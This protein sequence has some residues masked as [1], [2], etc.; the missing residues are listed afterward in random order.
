MVAA[1]SII[2]LLATVGG[3]V[4]SPK[5]LNSDITLLIDNDL[6]G[7]ESPTA[8]SGVIILGPR[9]L[10]DASTACQA[11]GEQLWSPELKTASIRPNLDYL[12]YTKSAQRQTKYWIAPK[13]V[14]TRTIDA[15]GDYAW[16]NASSRLPVLCSHTAPFS[17]ETI[18]DTSPKWQVT[19]RSN[20]EYLTGF[21]DR[22]S[23]RFLGLRYAPQPERFTYSEPYVGNGVNSSAMEYGSQC[24]QSGGGSEDCLFLN[25]WTNF[26]PG[27]H[28]SKQDLKPVMFWIHGGAFTSGTANDPNLDGGNLASRGDVVVVGINYRLGSLG[29]LALPDGATNGNFGL[30]DQINALD[31]VR[32]NVRDFGGDPNRI[33]IF[34]QSAGAGSVRA[35]MASPKSIGKFAGA[36]PLSN[37]GGINYGTTYSEYYTIA[38]EMEVAGT[39]ILS[40]TNCT[41]AQLPLDCLRALP[42]ETFTTLSAVARYP[43]VDGTY[44]TSNQL[45]LRGPP[46]PV[47]LMMGTTRDDG[48]PF[49]T[50]PTTTDEQ[51]YLNTSDF[52]I[53]PPDLFPIPN[54]TNKTLALF[55]MTSRLATDGIFRCIDQAT[56][57]TGLLTG[58]L[59]KQVYYYE[60]NRTY[61]ITGWPGLDICEPSK[62]ASH[63]YGD[64]R[65]EYFKCHSGELYYVFGNLGRQGL[66]MRDADD[67]PF[68]QLV[69]DSFAAFART[70]DPNP[71]AGF[72]ET[73]GYEGTLEEMRRSGRWEPATRGRGMTKRVLQ[74]PSSQWGFEEEE[75]C[76][77]LGLGLDY[78][79]K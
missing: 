68:E 59:G 42:A 66:P 6:Q 25:I 67:L 46:L 19:V 41:E 49:I 4:S 7:S 58:R 38:E 14:A 23:F 35:L 16:T 77:Q 51:T 61:Q 55:N 73:R 24:V 71:E 33:T 50:F 5:S 79:L 1:L 40:A 30:A 13:G 21:R 26:L 27:P 37:L 20:N 54:L 76:E 17:N 18:Q 69:L 10:K 22:Y 32:N 8:S 39:A 64:P 60:F 72:L 56:V 11:L 28:S 15:S 57:Y 70:G 36:I 3:A 12:I 62:T 44:L 78:Y 9:P 45:Q 48:A 75:Q 34:G 43:V 47:H 52:A 63:P 31:W 2:F 74:W 65:G 29:F 53:P